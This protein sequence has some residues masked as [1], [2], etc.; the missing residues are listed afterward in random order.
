MRCPEDIFSLRDALF[1]HISV[2]TVSIGIFPA[3]G[4]SLHISSLSLLSLSPHS[5]LELLFRWPLDRHLGLFRSIVAQPRKGAGEWGNYFRIYG[6][7]CSISTRRTRLSEEHQGQRL[8]EFNLETHL[9]PTPKRRQRQKIKVVPFGRFFSTLFCLCA[10]LSLG[11]FL[12]LCPSSGGNHYRRNLLFPFQ[13]S[14]L[15]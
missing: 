5:S 9:T 1:P 7:D 10:S 11:F 8:P 2:D 14:N 3:H 13:F 12:K 15:L 6:P 4:K